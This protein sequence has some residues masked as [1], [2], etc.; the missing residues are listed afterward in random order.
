MK[1]R[2]A[3]VVNT[4]SGGGAEMT[5]A[6]LSRKLSERYAVDIIVNDD[7]HLQ[8]L[9]SGRVISL[10]MPTNQ[11]RMDTFY[12]AKALIR[13][14]RLLIKLKKERQYKAVLSFSEMTNLANVLSGGKAIISVHNSIRNSCANGWKHRAATKIILPYC[15]RK[16]Y[17]TVPCSRE[18][19]DELIN[20]YGLCKDR[21]YVIYNGVDL[22]KI[23]ENTGMS[24]TKPICLDGE[25]LV[26]TAGRLIWEKGQWHLIRAI[27][28]LRTH[29]IPVKLLILGE[30]T[31]RTLLEELVAEAG[32]EGNVLLPGF[33]HNPHQYIAAADVVVFPSLTEGFSN[34]I[35]EALACGAPV[36]STDHETGAREIL[37]PNSDFHIKTKDTIEKAEYGILIPV[38][39]G[40]VRHCNEPSSKEEKMMAEAI[41]RVISDHELAS[42][43]RKAAL[44]R[45][46]QLRIETAAEEWIRLIEG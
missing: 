2:I 9:H 19:A 11:N 13:R 38:C 30:G 20:R 43:Y 24:L 21:G 35:V 36:V 27:K 42:H 32:L 46:E 17:R 34:A 39:D 44:R 18:I 33:V 8:Y 37:A 12:Q 4:L 16:A 31:K 7:A 41:H 29:N 28:E 23:K 25:K 40:K 1:E 14:S 10:G 6:N 26:V 22:E 5:A 45:A 15:L 3:I